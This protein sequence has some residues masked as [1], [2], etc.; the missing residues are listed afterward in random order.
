MLF[1]CRYHSD[2][3]DRLRGLDEDRAT[4][5]TSAPSSLAC[6][7]QV[8]SECAGLSFGNLGLGLEDQGPPHNLRAASAF[9][10]SFWTVQTVETTTLVLWRSRT[11]STDSL[12]SMCLLSRPATTSF[13]LIEKIGQTP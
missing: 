10:I 1:D 11:F 4:G 2:G 3:I 9:A 5:R 12:K 8:A 13:S 7:G 6:I